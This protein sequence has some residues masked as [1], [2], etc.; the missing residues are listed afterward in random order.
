MKK[1]LLMSLP[2]FLILSR[3][4]FA[5]T[6]RILAG[7][8]LGYAE[9]RE[10]LV[11][12]MTK[13]AKKIK[14]NY[15]CESDT[16]IK[17]EVS[18]YTKSNEICDHNITK[19]IIPN[20][21]PGK[22]YRYKLT[23]DEA[24]Y[25][26][27]IPLKFKTKEL[28]EFRKDAPTFSFVTG[29]CAYINDSIY[30]RPGEPY[31]QSPQIFKSMAETPGQFM[32]WLGDNTYLREVDMSSESGIKYR[33]YH[34]R[35]QKDLQKLLATKNNYAIWDDH[36]YG[37]NNSCKT[38]ELKNTTLQT[39]KEYWGNK[40]YGQDGEGIYSKMQWS[41]CDFFL[42][43][44]RYFRDDDDMP[45]S[46][47]PHKTQLG[48]KQL[49]WLKQSLI[50]SRA[51][52]KFIVMGGQFLNINTEQ[53]SYVQYMK[54]RKELLDFITN[55]NIKGVIFMTG[56][57]HH[58]EILKLEVGDSSQ[59]NAGPTP[60]KEKKKK[61][62]KNKT[63]EKNTTVNSEEDEPETPLGKIYYELT[64][65]PMTSKGSNVLKTKEA[66]NPLRIQQTLVTEPNY[67][68]LTVSG[69]KN[70]RNLLIKCYNNKGEL[71]WEFTINQQE[72]Q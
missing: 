43:D 35:K 9:H 69:A 4:A 13:C 36:D 31:G 51:S 20:L 26:T 33:Y 71:K 6:P 23:L 70:N 29:S 61:E 37:P 44:N 39:F 57:R 48:C 30:D 66:V 16:L 5:Q 42:L 32:L 55:M 22:T 12:V 58:T 49:D 28:W 34:T 14:L 46:L 67:C 47:L 27:D 15:N 41:D 17:G 72:L 8:M 64:C 1:R 56:D 25:K 7:P 65:S 3:F 50:S 18:Y 21:E 54:E 10:C 11:W 60:I 2:I 53:E 59:K 38:Y 62:K 52:F 68:Q 24:H 19:I 63:N 45:D 40:T